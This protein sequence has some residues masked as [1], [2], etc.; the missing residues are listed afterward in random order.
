MVCCCCTAAVAFAALQ[1]E[2][3]L[4][5]EPCLLE[6]ALDNPAISFDDWHDFKPAEV[7]LSIKLALAA[8]GLSADCPVARHVRMANG[9]NLYII[10]AFEA[11]SSIQRTVAGSS[12]PSAVL[13]RDPFMKHNDPPNLMLAKTAVWDTFELYVDRKQEGV[14]EEDGKVYLKAVSRPCGVLELW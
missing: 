7:D 3:R 9:S 10:S 14:K 2:Y 13:A 11:A 12:V 8:Q 4:L 6:K 5:D 1:F